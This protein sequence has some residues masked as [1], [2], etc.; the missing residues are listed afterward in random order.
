M[1]KASTLANISLS[2]IRS[3]LQPRH[4]RRWS[5]DSVGPPQ[6]QDG[7]VNRR[8][9]YRPKIMKDGERNLYMAPLKCLVVVF[10]VS[11]PCPYVEGTRSTVKTDHHA[12][13]QI[14][15][16][17]DGT[18]KLVRLRFRL[19]EY[20]FE[21]NHTAGAKHQAADA[22]SRRKTKE[23]DES[24]IDGD[25]PVMEVTT[26]ARSGRNKLV[27]TMP[28]KTLNDTKGPTLPKLEKFRSAQSNDA[29]YGKIRPTTRKPG[30]SSNLGKNGHLAR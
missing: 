19:I 28:E 6:K 27:D 24:D 11:L 20:V 25:I 3:T 5:T 4:R 8:V 10:A 29:Y 12:P 21:I 14:L 18:G 26:S 23:T 17:A 22:S 9:G 2:K 1:E 15:N 16:L 30:S 13:K 7:N